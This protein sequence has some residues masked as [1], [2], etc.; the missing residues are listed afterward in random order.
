[1]WRQI[2]DA[3]EIG[4]TWNSVSFGNIAIAIYYGSKFPERLP[5]IERIKKLLDAL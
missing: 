3:T 1:M 4:P 2:A 5:E